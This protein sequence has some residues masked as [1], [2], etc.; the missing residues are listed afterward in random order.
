VGKESVDFLPGLVRPSHTACERADACER[1]HIPWGHD[2]S[3]R[4]PVCVAGQDPVLCAVGAARDLR[5]PKLRCSQPEDGDR[6][7]RG[8][9]YPPSHGRWGWL[10]TQFEIVSCL[11]GRATGWKW[12]LDR[13]NLIYTNL[14][15]KEERWPEDL[16]ASADPRTQRP[17]PSWW[18][19]SQRERFPR[20]LTRRQRKRKTLRKS[21]GG[22]SQDLREQQRAQKF[23]QQT[24]RA[25]LLEKLQDR[26]GKTATYDSSG[27]R[28]SQ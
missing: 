18:R 10:V 1:Q 7:G 22:G 26:D 24:K 15:C 6:H 23:S 9:R 4:I 12:M 19:G 5:W 14:Q 3:L 25:R 11:T 8:R 21:R 2:E 13:L 27:Q 28:F 16:E 17:L 20:N